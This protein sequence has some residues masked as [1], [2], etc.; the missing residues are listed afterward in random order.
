MNKKLNVLALFPWY[1]ANAPRFFADAFEQLGH[2]VFR[3]G[4]TYFDHYGLQ[5]PKDELP[6]VDHEIVR[7]SPVWNLN[8][9]LDVAAKNGIVP[10]LIFL[11]EETYQT[12][13]VPTDKVPVVLWSA[14]GWPDAFA[15][16]KVI[17]PTIAYT[18]HPFGVNPAPQLHIPDGWKFLPA[19][20]STKFHKYLNLPERQIDFTLYCT[21]Y[22][23][24]QQLCDE[25]SN[26]GF[27]V[28][29]GQRT[30]SD[31]VYGYNNGLFTYHNCNGQAE[32]KWRFL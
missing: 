11:S 10:D 15:R 31:Y 19:G 18:Q 4:P 28:S 8:G 25:L 14:D 13:I 24:R 12:R 2:R 30:I 3:V 23:K 29:S 5:W 22:G 16:K 26:L 9:C 20:Y 6:L 17:Q 21:M 1:P 7:E 27:E 32:V